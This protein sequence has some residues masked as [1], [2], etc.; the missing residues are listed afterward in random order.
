MELK[1]LSF[2]IWD[3]PLWFVKNR[4]ERLLGTIKYLRDLDADIVCLQESF[5]VKHRKILHENLK[6]I[7]FFSGAMAKSRKVLFFKVFDKSG[8]LVTLSKYPIL[9]SNF[10][11]YS[12]VFN[13]AVGEALARKGFLETVVKTPVGELKVVN[14]H[15]HEET[16]LFDRTL[17]LKQ[18]GK[19]FQQFN[20]R[21]IPAI[22]VGDFN[23]HSMERQED[24]SELFELI[25]FYHPLRYNNESHEAPTY[26]PG[27]PYVESWP[28]RTRGPKRFDYILVKG[29]KQM[30]LHAEY[31]HPQYLNPPLS[32]HDPLLLVLSEKGGG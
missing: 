8:G 19:I 17:R 29:L 4:K 20:G 26:R 32:D 23:Q 16:F 12:R 9:Q 3:L 10:V 30:G 15:L 25:G 11:P 2:N 27:N 6:D 22:L 21:G 18:L 31:Y 28:N 13:S 7:Y 24:F 1:V 14:T 5:D